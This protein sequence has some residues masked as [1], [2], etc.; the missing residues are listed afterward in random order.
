VIVELNL[1]RHIY[2]LWVHVRYRGVQYLFDVY[3]VISL[4]YWFFLFDVALSYKL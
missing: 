3:L 1:L 4:N 2:L